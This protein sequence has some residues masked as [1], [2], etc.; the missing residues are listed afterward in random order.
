MSVWL[1]GSSA[2]GIS[3]AFLFFVGPLLLALTAQAAQAAWISISWDAERP[4]DGQ[5]PG[6]IGAYNVSLTPEVLNSSG[7]RDARPATRNVK[8]GKLNRGVKVRSTTDWWEDSP[9][10]RD[11]VFRGALLVQPRLWLATIHEPA[12]S[13]D[14]DDPMELAMSRQ[15]SNVRASATRVSFTAGG[16]W[17]SHDLRLHDVDEVSAL[18]PVTVV[19]DSQG[20]VMTADRPIGWAFKFPTISYEVSRTPERSRFA[21]A[22]LF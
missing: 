11:P 12:V 15:W 1:R 5:A 8:R 21:L 19:F 6:L 3:L 20:L 22:G 13:I 17:S 4:S 14:S 9:G 10:P 7:I 2:R 16:A 18:I